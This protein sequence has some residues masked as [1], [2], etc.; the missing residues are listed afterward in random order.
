MED[1]VILIRKQF[2]DFVINYPYGNDGRVVS[3]V[4]PATK[5]NKPT[6]RAIPKE[7]F[8]W[9]NQETTTIKDG[10]LVV[11]KESIENDEE[12]AY[13]VEIIENIDK[14]EESILSINEAKEILSKGNHLSLKKELNTLIEGKSE[15]LANNIKK[16]FV[17]LAQEIGVDSIAKRKVI[18][19]WAN[20]DIEMLDVLF[21]DEE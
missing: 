5:G 21:E 17:M 19:V 20:L 11:K 16:N 15:T 3:Y 7:V 4:F 2:T 13:E 9:L 18:G 12:V 14:M 1:S 10:H 8:R 6:E